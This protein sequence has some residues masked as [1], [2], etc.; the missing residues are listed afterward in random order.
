MV[1]RTG[2]FSRIIGLNQKKT[3]QIIESS[4][5]NR[6]LFLFYLILIILNIVRINSIIF[7]F[8][9][10]MDWNWIFHSFPWMSLFLLLS[11]LLS[12]HAF[13]NFLPLFSFIGSLQNSSFLSI[14]LSLFST[15]WWGWVKP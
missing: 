4:T 1:L 11:T 9:Y 2:L 12:P 8:I 14:L 6:D 5:L 10:S 13:I 15:K 7:F 3:I